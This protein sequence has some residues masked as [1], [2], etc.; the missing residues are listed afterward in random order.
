MKQNL[1]VTS[2]QTDIPPGVTLVSKTDLKGAITYAND[3][4][5]EVS[6]YPL[7]E[8]LHQNHNIVRHPDMPPAAFEDMWSTLK[9]GQPWRGIVKNRCKDGGYYWVDACVVP[10]K[11][12]DQVIGYMSVRKHA[13]PAA[14]EAAEALYR[15]MAAGTVRRRPRPPAWLGIRNGMRAGS[16]F[17]AFLMLAGG[18]LGIGGLKLAD[19]AFSRLYHAQLEPVA[20]IGKI[21]TRLSES[22]ATMLEIRLARQEGSQAGQDSQ[23]TALDSQVAKLRANRDEINSLLGQL[24]GAADQVTRQMYLLT[25]ALNRYTSDGLLPV[26]QAAARDDPQRVDQLVSQRVLPLEQ[27]A[28]TAAVDL[29]NSLITA[30]RQEYEDTLARNNRIRNFAIG[31]ILFGLAVVA[32]VGHMFI[33]GIVDPLNASIR[34][35]NRIAQGDLQ[36]EIDLSG[37][38]ESGQ[39]NHAAAVMQLHL[40]VM[41]DEIALAARRIHQHCATLNIALYE[42]TEHS[43]EQH[44]RVYSAVRSLD[45]AVAETSDLSERAERLLNLASEFDASG[46]GQTLVGET[47]ELATATRLAAFGADEVAGA[48]RQ[49]AELIVENRGEAQRAWLASEELK[50]TAGELKN[51][52]DYFE[53]EKVANT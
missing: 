17:V 26:E 28:T 14:I 45:D 32:L 50:R 12:H 47:R 51:L 16:L 36:G 38:G 21:E 48:M 35:L 53:P 4:F 39:L 46:I 7:D 3:A 1:P 22:R 2:R 9:R 18:A 25:E 11:R 13:T 15:D 31:G 5:V 43:E 27:A 29:R 40:K 42:V 34:R 49:V 8:L 30:A 20:T 19:D 44:D 41:I 37:T 33:R 10:V 6:G 24:T 52:V 23:L